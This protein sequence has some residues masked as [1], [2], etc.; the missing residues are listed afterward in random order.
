[1]TPEEINALVNEAG[2]GSVEAKI[3][4]CEH[5]LSDYARIR[6]RHM[7]D[8]LYAQYIKLFWT[9]LTSVL[10][11]VIAADASLKSLAIDFQQ[12]PALSKMQN[13]IKRTLQSAMYCSQEDYRKC[14]ALTQRVFVALSSA[15]PQLL[16][17]YFGEY[18][19][20]DT[21]RKITGSFVSNPSFSSFVE[22][23]KSLVDFGKNTIEENKALITFMDLL[24]AYGDIEAS[25]NKTALNPRISKIAS[26]VDCVNELKFAQK[27]WKAEMGY[28]SAMMDL[29]TMYESGHGTPVD[30]KK[31]EGWYLRAIQAGEK[32][33]QI[34]LNNLRNK[35]KTRRD[36]ER[37]DA[38]AREKTR[39]ALAESS[40]RIR[41][42]QEKLRIE[43]NNA[44][45]LSRHNKELEEIKRR[46]AAAI[47]DRN[48]IIK[49][50]NTPPEEKM[51][52]LR[53][54]WRQLYDDGSKGLLL[55]DEM[56]VMRATYS[57]LITGGDQAIRNFIKQH[58][59]VY[60]STRITDV[61]MREY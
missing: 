22:M 13:L 49:E 11:N 21:S 27:K 45:E 10:P 16:N 33:G 51:V 38:L 15:M 59:V 7:L 20:S 56:E 48:A 52:N 17:V 25:T 19:S 34:L 29:G 37:Q 50:A 39:I 1:M 32:Q 40:E 14:T 41:I 30:E 9:Q 58:F 61:G 12:E 36:N 46:E 55:T 42:E 35:Q 54:Q 28:T 60:A 23:V 4:L 24:D 8:G 44:E 26:R 6:A 57:A 53:F 31:A 43:Q 3:T 18:A 2:K 5:Y 47:E